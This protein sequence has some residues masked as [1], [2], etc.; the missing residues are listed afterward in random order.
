MD[1]KPPKKRIERLCSGGSVD[2]QLLRGQSQENDEICKKTRRFLVLQSY[3]SGL[4]IAHLLCRSIPIEQVCEKL[5][6]LSLKTKLNTNL[7]QREDIIEQLR[8]STGPA[9]NIEVRPAVKKELKK[10]EEVSE[11]CVLYTRTQLS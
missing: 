9:V 5:F 1:R 11:I 3:R 10:E 6:W 8:N 2:P 4:P 7:R